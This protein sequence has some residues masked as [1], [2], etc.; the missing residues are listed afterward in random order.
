MLV[1]PLNVQITQE[2]DIHLVSYLDKEPVILNKIDYDYFTK[3]PKIYYE[4][5]EILPDKYDIKFSLKPFSG[6]SKVFGNDILIGHGSGYFYNNKFYA[7]HRDSPKGVNFEDAKNGII[8]RGE[9][10]YG[11]TSDEAGVLTL[12]NIYKNG[13]NGNIINYNSFLGVSNVIVNGCEGRM[14]FPNVELDTFIAKVTHL[15]GIIEYLNIPY[16]WSGS[17]SK[18][19]IGKYLTILPKEEG[20]G[21]YDS[22]NCWIDK[23]GTGF[24]NIGFKQDAPPEDNYWAISGD[25]N[26]RTITEVNLKIRPCFKGKIIETKDV[27]WFKSLPI[28]N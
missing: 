7:N 14:Y 1:T 2:Y 27:E 20:E 18:L 16:I 17:F 21:I 24:Y 8:L 19:H 23:N 12:L 10:Y 6:A 11:F 3:L 15:D 22:Q 5:I 28:I 13:V 4:S 9:G 26:N 25:R